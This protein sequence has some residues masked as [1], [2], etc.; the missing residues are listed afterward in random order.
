MKICTD[1]L[2][3][4]DLAKIQRILAKNFKHLFAAQVL[5]ILIPTLH[6]ALVLVW[7][8]RARC[9]RGWSIAKRNC[10]SPLAR[11]RF[12]P[13]RD[14]AHIFWSKK[15]GSGAATNDSQTYHCTQRRR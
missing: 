10:P 9:V 8:M 13:C 5:F 15:I 14:E 4:I 12:S 2:Q 3:A 7:M 6:S 11:L 1:V